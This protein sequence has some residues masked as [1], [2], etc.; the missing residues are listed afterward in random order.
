MIDLINLFLGFFG[1]KAVKIADEQADASQKRAER[2]KIASEIKAQRAREAVLQAIKQLKA[3]NKKINIAN[4]SRISGVARNTA[5]KYLVSLNN[6][7]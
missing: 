2:A 7:S 6:I 3:E 5:K 4:V 1:Y